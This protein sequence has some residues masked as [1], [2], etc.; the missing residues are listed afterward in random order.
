MENNQLKYGDY[1]ISLQMPTG[2]DDQKIYYRWSYVTKVQFF[3]HFT[4]FLTH[5]DSK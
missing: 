4:D 3:V 5:H 1:V 2:G